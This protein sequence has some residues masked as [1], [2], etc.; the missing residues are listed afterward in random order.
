M[1]QGGEKKL[2]ETQS[3]RGEIMPATNW[4]ANDAKLAKL[5]NTEF[6]VVQ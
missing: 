1:S 5:H 6:H 3:E 4:P 2:N